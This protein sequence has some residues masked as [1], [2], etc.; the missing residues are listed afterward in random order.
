[1]DIDNKEARD[2]FVRML[3]KAMGGYGKP[4][5]DKDSIEVWMEYLAPFSLR[6]I[7][8]AFSAYCDEES[9]FPPVPAAIRNL[10]KQADG[11]PG[12]EEAWAIAVTSLDERQTVVWTAETFE[13][14]NICK[15]VFQNGGAIAARKAFTEAYIRLVATSRL[16]NAPVAWSAAIGWDKGH[17]EAVL[18]S[19]AVAGYLPAQNVAALLPA[20]VEKANDVDEQTVRGNLQKIR[21]LLGTLEPASKRAE[22]AREVLVQQ[23]RDNTAAAKSVARLLV[24]S[25][26]APASR[27]ISHAE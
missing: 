8:I 11:R 3:K 1:M 10:C 12:S 9:K 16:G 20:P 7:A 24:E 27:E 14:F 26:L 6:R 15:P 23:E 19:A 17:R 18:K 25:Y 5:P 13:A 2:Q 22:R 21:D 4:L